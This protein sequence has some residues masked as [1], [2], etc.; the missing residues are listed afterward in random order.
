M[1][2]KE[3]PSIDLSFRTG[4][5]KKVRTVG[6]IIAELQKLPPNLRTAKPVRVS[7]TDWNDKRLAL[8][9]EEDW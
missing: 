9:I 5:R 3:D 8:V 1:P 6:D 4:T 2:C 7:V